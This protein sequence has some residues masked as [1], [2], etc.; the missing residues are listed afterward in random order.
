MEAIA[1]LMNEHR[2]I[3]RALDALVAFTDEVERGGGD[4]AELS[5]FVTFIRE[6]A[7]GHH[8]GKEED[9]LFAAMVEAGFPRQAG[10]VAVMLAEHEEGRAQVRTLAELASQNAP[11]STADRARLARAAQGYA[12]LLEAH[13]QKEDGI[14]YPMAERRLPPELLERVEEACR[15]RQAR[16][17]ES[18]EL[19]QLS[20]L[21]EQLFAQ[22]AT[23]ARPPVERAQHH[24]CCG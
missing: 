7:D 11:W 13:I 17:S 3:E 21:A 1:T 24:G 18:G 15:T 6:F 12:S 2:L 20:A 23:P 5:R 19:E 8:H 14:L 4:Q 9:V 16:A 10:P 22:R